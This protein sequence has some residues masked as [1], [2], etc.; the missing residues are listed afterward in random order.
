MSAEYGTDAARLSLLLG[1]T[2]GNDMRLSEEKIAGFR[3]FTNKLWNISRYILAQ[4]YNGQPIVNEELTLADR[5]ILS[6]LERTIADTTDKIKNF[7]FSGAGESLRLFSLDDLAD[8]YLEA[9]K[10]EGSSQKA[11]VLFYILERIL[12]LWHPFMPFVTETVWE[13]WGKTKEPLLIAAWP[14]V[15]QTLINE[16]AES[17]FEHV[18][19]VIVSIRNL[20]SEHKIPPSEKVKAVIQ[21]EGADAILKAQTL[22]RSLRTGVEELMIGEAME[23]SL[24]ARVGTIDIYLIV[25]VDLVAEKERLEKEL[26]KIKMLIINLAARL[27]NVEFSSKAPAHIVETENK[28]LEDYKSN[29]EKISARL[30][31]L[32]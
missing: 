20:R 8:W 17:A 10:F 19:E 16:A 25:E 4:E 31:E 22:V 26:V 1:N 30:Q 15:N 2:P 28:K 23:N 11:A 13:A 7:D 21:G 14:E 5:W 29:A 32:K 27:D 12:K 9:S 24:Y 3:N 18:R 6:R